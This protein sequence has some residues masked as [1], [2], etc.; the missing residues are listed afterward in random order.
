MTMADP[1]PGASSSIAG[2]GRESVPEAPC[3]DVSGPGPWLLDERQWTD[4]HGTRW[5][6]R[7]RPIEAYAAAV[8][9]LL[10]CPG[11]HVVYSDGSGPY[12]VS[13]RRREELLERVRR[14]VVSGAEPPS[15]FSP[16]EFRT[17][18]GRIMLVVQKIY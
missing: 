6:M 1:V 5:F 2:P 15:D 7:G 3:A 17:E 13:G 10:E 11:L 8:R 14:S 9:R 4:A 12:E 18:D 16:A